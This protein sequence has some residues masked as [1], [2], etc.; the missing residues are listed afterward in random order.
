MKLPGSKLGRAWMWIGVSVGALLCGIGY[1]SVSAVAVR[2]VL[3]LLAVCF[4]LLAG[5][6]QW[7]TSHEPT[8]D[9]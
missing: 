9:R 1:F 5:W 3:G 7:R 4:A 6:L 2:V 8:Q